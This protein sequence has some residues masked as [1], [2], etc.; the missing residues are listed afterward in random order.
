MTGPSSG[1]RAN[2]LRLCRRCFKS[3]LRI[4]QWCES[5]PI[6]RKIGTD[7]HPCISNE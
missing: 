4:M 1:V 3:R 2:I 6:L 5:V 7:S